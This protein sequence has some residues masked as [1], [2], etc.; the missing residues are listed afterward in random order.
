VRARP[1]GD[2]VLGLWMDRAI[3]GGQVAAAQRWRQLTEREDKC[4]L[5]ELA[6][7]DADVAAL[8]ADDLWHRRRRDGAC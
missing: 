8:A 4:S 1:S 6:C 7:G 3:D 2:W 5:S